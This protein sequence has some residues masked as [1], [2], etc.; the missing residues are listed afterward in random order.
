MRI[1]ESLKKN[2]RRGITGLGLLL[3]GLV[4]IPLIPLILLAALVAF[5]WRRFDEWRLRQRFEAKWGKE[6][7]ELVLVYSNS[8]HWKDRFEDEI[9]PRIRHKAVV[10][11]W[12]ERSTNE[13]K[14]RPLDVRIFR[15]WGGDREFN[16]MA[17]VFPPGGKTRTI[18]FWQAY[19]DFRHGKTNPLR[20]REAELF[21]ALGVPSGERPEVPVIRR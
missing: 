2:L 11:N 17:I 5:V 10:L 19:R 9:L 14:G 6:G 8:P 4:L 20:Q 12:S 13:W 21:D 1:G 16:P 3:A 18:R 7:K 15:R